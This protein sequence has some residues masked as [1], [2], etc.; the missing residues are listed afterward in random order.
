ML[1]FVDIV[2]VVLAIV[3]KLC[4]GVDHESTRTAK[5]NWG[6]RFGPLTN[7]TTHHLGKVGFLYSFVVRGKPITKINAFL[8]FFIPPKTPK[9][10]FLVSCGSAL[11]DS[12]AVHSCFIK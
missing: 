6:A 12:S 5:A 8:A 1:F 7:L 9:I 10:V 11:D 3:S 2:F 4:A